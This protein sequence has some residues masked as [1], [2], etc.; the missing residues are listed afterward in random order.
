MCRETH[1][2]IAREQKQKYSN[3]IEKQ[4]IKLSAV[5][6]SGPGYLAVRNDI[7]VKHLVSSLCMCNRFFFVVV[8]FTSVLLPFCSVEASVI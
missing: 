1:K 5:G 4:S 2:L 7:S 6:M 3:A 8:R